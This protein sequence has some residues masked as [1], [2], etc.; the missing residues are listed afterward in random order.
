MTIKI[1]GVQL[2][3]ESFQKDFASLPDEV[4]T[5]FGQKIPTLIEHPSA[6][7]LRLHD[8][9]G[10]KPKIFK[11]DVTSSGKMY[12]ATFHLVGSVAVFLRVAIHK[13]IDRRPI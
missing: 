9:S 7:R 11:I 8:L 6:S 4:K 2:G 5:A 12:Q 10:F 13:E 1:T 3:K